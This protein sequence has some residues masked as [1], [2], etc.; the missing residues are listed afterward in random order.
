M[1]RGSDD[2]HTEKRDA[3]QSLGAVYDNYDVC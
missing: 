2:G 3:L 1:M